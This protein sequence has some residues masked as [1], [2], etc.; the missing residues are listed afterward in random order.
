M[1]RRPGEGRDPYA[2]ARIVAKEDNDQRVK[3][4]SLVGKVQAC[5][6]TTREISSPPRAVL[7]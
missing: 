7:P 1:N 2:A 3:Q 6:G 5:A 4:L